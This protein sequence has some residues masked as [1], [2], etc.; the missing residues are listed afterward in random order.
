MERHDAL[1]Q[2]L[3]TLETRFWTAIKDR[4][5]G[6]AARLSDDPSLVV[7]AQGVGELHRDALARMLDEATYELHGFSLK[8]VHL[9]PIGRDAVALAYTVEEDLTVD[10]KKL[11]LK[12]FD[13]SVWAKKDG[14]WTCVL[15]T[16]SPAGD[17]FGRH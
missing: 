7:G 1:Q 16:E 3:L 14:E 5:S 8:D 9:R 10:G 15:H 11:A 13:T 17:P 4:D 12:A 6:T 2:E